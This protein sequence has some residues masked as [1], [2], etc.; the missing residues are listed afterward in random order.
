MLLEVRAVVTL[1]R[2]LDGSEEERALRQADGI[3]SH[4]LAYTVCSFCDNST[5]CILMMCGLFCA[6][7][8]S[9]PNTICN[10]G[11]AVS[12]ECCKASETLHEFLKAAILIR[13]LAWVPVVGLKLLRF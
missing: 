1:G 9:L 2:G 8:L 3:F 12:S 5:H 11:E 4:G 10:G 7:K 13:F 6:Q